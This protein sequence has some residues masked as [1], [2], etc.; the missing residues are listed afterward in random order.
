[1]NKYY[2][3]LRVLVGLGGCLLASASVPLFFSPGLMASIHG[4]LGLGEFPWQPIAIYL[5]KST[6]LMYAVHGSVMLFVAVNF[7]AYRQLVP[8]L[9]II[10]VALGGALLYI[11]LSAGMPWWWTAFEGPPVASLG[12]L[13]LWLYQ[14]AVRTE[15]KNRA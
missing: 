10:H 15:Q 7:A 11:D 12:V 6:S 3:W 1:M 9:G 14:K 8:L 2:R 13:F 5:A 4:A